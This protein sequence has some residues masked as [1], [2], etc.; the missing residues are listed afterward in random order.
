M[1]PRIL[2]A[3]RS[4]RLAKKD[5]DLIWQQIR[6]RDQGGNADGG[7]DDGGA[8][9][10]HDELTDGGDIDGFAPLGKARACALRAQLHPFRHKKKWC[11]VGSSGLWKWTTSQNTWI[12]QHTSGS[13]SLP[14]TTMCR[15]ILA[16]RTPAISRVHGKSEEWR[17]L[18]TS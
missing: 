11:Q 17:L 1:Q 12:V 14:N 4:Q 8:L 16:E 3:R 6:P 7:D 18:Q 9:S 2:L 13:S 5:R 10:V 15:D